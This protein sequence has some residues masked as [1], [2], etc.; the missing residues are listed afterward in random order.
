LEPPYPSA[1]DLLMHMV[2]N[3]PALWVRLA[4]PLQYGRDSCDMNGPDIFRLH[5]LIC[6]VTGLLVSLQQLRAV[7]VIIYGNYSAS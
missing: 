5:W 2:E 1:M 3:R 7:K 4:V 6:T